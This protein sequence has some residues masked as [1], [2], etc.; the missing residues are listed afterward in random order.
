[1][2]LILGGHAQQL[3]IAIAEGRR[4]QCRAGKII[5]GIFMRNILGQRRACLFGEQLKIGNKRCK[6]Q[7]G[8]NV[9]FYAVHLAFVKHAGDKAAQHGRGHIVGVALNGR[10]HCEHLT[11][12]KLVAQHCVCAQNTGHDAAGAG[13]KAARHGNG[14]LLCDAQA[15]HGNIQLVKHRFGAAVHKV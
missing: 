11:R 2:Q 10:G 13:A 5:H 1:M 12:S 6:H 15:R 14:I 3:V 4:G 9:L 7:A 8:I